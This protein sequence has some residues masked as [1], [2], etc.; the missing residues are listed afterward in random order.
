VSPQQSGAN[1]R[2][3]P[4]GPGID[5]SGLS[6]D[7]RADSPQ[8]LIWRAQELIGPYQLLQPIGSGGM[9][10]VWLAEQT[11]PVRRRVAL[12]LIKAGMDT[13]EVVARFQSERQALALMDHPSIAKVFD[14][15]S[16][17][18]GRPYFV[19]EYIAGI[20]ITTYCDQRKMTLRQRLELF[21]QVCEGVQHAHQKA[22]IHRDLKPSNILVGE[23]D[24]K[25]VPRIIDFGIAK[26]ISQH[27]TAETLFTQTG[28]I[29]GTPAYMSPEQA[30]SSG[31]DVDTRTD[32]YSL[33]V[34]LYELLVGVRPLDFHELA[35]DEILRRLREQEAPRPSTRLRTLGGK[36]W[37]TAQDRGADPPTLARQLRGD[38]D[39]IAL[40]ALEKDRSRRYGS[41]S[42]LAA[43][44]E[45]YLKYEAVLAVPPSAAYRARKFARRYRGVLITVSAF[46]LVLI[47]AA[48]VSI[49]QS[50]LATKQRDRADAEAA[51]AQAV[52]DF[53]QNDLLA[54]ASAANQ[55]G[56]TAKPDPHLEV[57][58]ALDR[59][60]ARIGGKF[61]QQPEVEAAIRDTIGQ[62]Y[63]E[64]GLYPEARTQL[65][66]ALTLHRRALGAE[67]PKTLQTMSR[68]GRILHLLGK[69]AQAEALL[70]QTLQISH[71]VLGPEHPDTLASMNNLANVYTAQGKY[72]QAESLYSQTL[73]ARR[74]KLGAEHPETLASMNNLANLYYAQGKYSQAEVLYAKTVEIKRRVLGTE[75]PD[76]LTSVN[77]LAAVYRGQGK[78]AQAEALHSQTL[79][80]RRRVL[81]PEHPDTLYSMNNLANIYE[82]EGKYAE[83]ETL[84]SHT[85]KIKRRV[86]G[87]EHPSTLLSMEN[88]ACAYSDQSKYAQ[89]EA[90]FGQTLGIERRALSPESHFTLNTLSDMAFMYQRERKYAL[91]ETY[92]AEVLAAWQH[93][94]GPVSA[95]RMKAATDVALAY[96][97]RGKFIESEPLAR[98]AVEFER[99]KQP[100]DWQR[101]R[102]ESLLGASLAG[103]KQYTEAEPL[104]L[105]GYRGMLARKDR[106]A[107]P[108]RYHLDRGR[109]W[110]VQLYQAW[111]K[112]EK[113]AQWKKK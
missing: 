69:L 2:S 109:E 59:A 89:A 44:I 26:A 18:Q 56:A 7:P 37:A 53:L 30:G 107:V 85:L 83:A 79:E 87:S 97:S 45:R 32:V 102:A 63:A 112:P 68:F 106:I 93:A 110:I 50:V 22:I 54:Q 98:E 27:L 57:R 92:A 23:V 12:K 25:P 81:G 13:G 15:G 38:L 29:L 24:G 104:L 95:V 64:L 16:T 108:E 61:N 4:E 31:A 9:G 41:P 72:P 36:S 17:L 14:A 90:L 48:V 42:D 65:E 103:Q 5:I 94:L 21:I 11:Q 40:K 74:H 91:A 52:N 78:Y 88:L 101:F 55:S 111:D 3:D 35:F 67:N 8:A 86:L 28:A 77:N 43:D 10:E 49:R 70:G 80:I 96:L 19:M 76:T 84:H 20:P 66:R 51:V 39:A 113:A 1:D 99:L 73:E 33:G 62:T 6:V 100:D 105:E 71:R 34:V 46:V 47:L 58:T 75:H 82:A 60:A